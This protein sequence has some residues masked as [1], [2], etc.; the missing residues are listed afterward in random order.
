MNLPNWI[1]LS[2]LLLAVPFLIVLELPGREWWA[3]GI[4]IVASCTDFIDGYLAR[5]LN[6]ETSLGALLDP[7][8]DKV[9]V[10]GAL[11]ALASRG[12]VPAWSVT[13][14]LFREFLV[15]GLRTLE[16]QRGIVLSAGMLG[17]LKT[18]LQMV[19]ICFLLYALNPTGPGLT[20]HVFGTIGVWLYWAAVVMTFIS[21]AQYLWAGRDLL[22]T[23]NQDESTGL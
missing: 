21:G 12:A 13:L 10:T 20:T 23:P 19:A 5:K 3:L 15:T 22:K 6:L 9:L 8:V 7:L 1:T 17:K 4:F 18:V 11:I 2:R 14:I 16:A